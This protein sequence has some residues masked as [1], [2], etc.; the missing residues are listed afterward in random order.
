V[1]DSEITTTILR[2][3][4]DEVLELRADAKVQRAEANAFRSEVNAK[5]VELQVLI[6]GLAQQLLLLTGYV[7]MEIE[8]LKKQVA[9][10]EERVGLT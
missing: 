5:F 8:L 6:Q 7:K 3:I 10:L 4:R 1:T 9:R 2:Q